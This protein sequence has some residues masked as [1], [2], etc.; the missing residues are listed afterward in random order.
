MFHS[1]LWWGFSGL[2]WQTGS[3]L[4][5]YGK[6]DVAYCRI[7]PKMKKETK[8]T[9]LNKKLASTKCIIYP[10]FDICLERSWIKWFWMSVCYFKRPSRGISNINNTGLKNLPCEIWFHISGK[11][12]FDKDHTWSGSQIYCIHIYSECT[13]W[14]M[15]VYE[16]IV[17]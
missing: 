17:S 7:W 9:G 12:Q 6:S 4:L 15:N 14:K 2:F 10:L 5:S 3:F 16:L 11:F 1:S 13:K 8:S